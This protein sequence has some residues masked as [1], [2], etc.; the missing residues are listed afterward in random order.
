MINIVPAFSLSLFLCLFM[1]TVRCL[2]AIAPN[3]VLIAPKLWMR[4]QCCH[5]MFFVNVDSEVIVPE[6]PLAD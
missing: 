3:Y 1:G 4:Q 6:C 5:K 2:F